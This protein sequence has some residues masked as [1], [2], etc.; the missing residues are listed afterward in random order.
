LHRDSREPAILKLW[1][2]CD[3]DSCVFD[4]NL[5]WAVDLCVRDRPRQ[6]CE[7]QEAHSEEDHGRP[8]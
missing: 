8:A 4:Q 1:H 3:T 7:D 2:Q 5:R 6:A